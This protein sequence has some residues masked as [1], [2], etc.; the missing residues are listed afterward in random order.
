MKLKYKKP[1]LEFFEFISEDIITTSGGEVV[2]PTGTTKPLT[3]VVNPDPW[4]D[5]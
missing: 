2:V 5:M 3:D 1:S 4:G